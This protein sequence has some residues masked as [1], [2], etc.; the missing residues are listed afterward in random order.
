MKLQAL[1]LVLVVGFFGWSIRHTYL[2]FQELNTL[3][4]ETAL[5]Y[6]E[7]AKLEALQ[8]EYDALKKA[9][10]ERIQELCDFAGGVPIGSYCFDPSALIDAECKYKGTGG[11]YITTKEGVIKCSQ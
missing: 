4:A 11:A 5:Y 9:N 1:F 8:E 2:T 6:E 3:K 7:L 10:L